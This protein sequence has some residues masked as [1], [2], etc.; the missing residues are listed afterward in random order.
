MN[1]LQLPGDLGQAAVSKVVVSKVVLLV[2]VLGRVQSAVRAARAS[3]K[4]SQLELLQPTS[5]HPPAGWPSAGLVVLR[6]HYARQCATSDLLAVA[7]GRR[8]EC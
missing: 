6:R 7:C 5:K 3:L 8:S 2:V 4:K 1:R